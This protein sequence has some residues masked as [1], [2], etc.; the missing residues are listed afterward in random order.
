MNSCHEVSPRP[1]KPIVAGTRN[2]RELNPHDSTNEHR[3]FLAIYRLGYVD[4]TVTGTR[5]WYD[6]SGSRV[7]VMRS[8]LLAVPLL[9]P[10]PSSHHSVLTEDSK[11]AQRCSQRVPQT[12]E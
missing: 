1:L 3:H 6:S 12:V 2:S 8:A 5:R 10:I 11:G 4:R 7:G 9:T